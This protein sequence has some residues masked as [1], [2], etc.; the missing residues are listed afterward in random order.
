MPLLPFVSFLSLGIV[1]RL[2]LSSMFL[3]DLLMYFFRK[4]ELSCQ[5]NGRIQHVDDRYPTRDSHR[6]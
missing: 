5:N 2:I 1:R 6:W 3:I 4:Y